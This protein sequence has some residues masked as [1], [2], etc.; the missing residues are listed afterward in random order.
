MKNI[1]FICG[2][3]IFWSCQN[4]QNQSTHLAAKDEDSLQSFFPVTDYLKGQVAIIK[5][6][7]INPLKIVS[8]PTQTD[9]TWVKM[10]DLDPLF[11]EFLTPI[12][13]TV[14]LQNRYNQSRF[15]DQTID[16]YTLTYEAK[17]TNNLAAGL[18]RWEVYVSPKSN[19]V[20]RVYLLKKLPQQNLL[21]LTWQSNQYSKIVEVLPAASS[22]NQSPIIKTT[23]VIWKF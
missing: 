9:S 15:Y 11:A 17:D 21:Q 22:V 20:T 10:E 7:P 16:L 3:L 13:D 8:T 19:M 18:L 4:K 6:N 23:S 12:I 1:L 14:N 5:A 2:L